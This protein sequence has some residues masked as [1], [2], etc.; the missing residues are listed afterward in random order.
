MLTRWCLKD[1]ALPRDYTANADDLYEADDTPDEG[2]S[3]GRLIHQHPDYMPYVE[4]IEDGGR[5]AMPFGLFI[6]IW[7]TTEPQWKSSLTGWKH[8]L[9]EPPE[10][11]PFRDHGDALF[12]CQWQRWQIFR[13]WQNTNRNLD[14][15]EIACEMTRDEWC[16]MTT[17]DIEVGR[18]I[19]SIQQAPS[20]PHEVY[21][22]F[23]DLHAALEYEWKDLRRHGPLDEYVEAVHERL[24]RHGIT[25]EARLLPNY[26]DQ[27]KL[28]T[29]LEYV[30]FEYFW[31]EES[32]N[33]QPENPGLRQDHHFLASWAH[34][35]IAL[36]AEEIERR[37]GVHQEI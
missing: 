34:S 15:D 16:R 13:A 30:N 20:C 2:T 25:Q 1:L 5:P 21:D 23:L 3:L 37:R 17:G 10:A 29:W 6:S 12:G 9:S 22:E 35:Q 32:G 27:D 31:Y 28:T 36:V 19:E 18:S 4:L 14:N 33:Q 11:L 8:L 24:S 26:R 7:D